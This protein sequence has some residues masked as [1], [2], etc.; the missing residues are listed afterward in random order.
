M[1][2]ICRIPVG[3]DLSKEGDGGVALI[4]DNECGGEDGVTVV[5]DEDCPRKYV[6]RKHD[7]NIMRLRVDRVDTRCCK[8]R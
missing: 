7:Q 6:K 2:T 3:K 4:L 8:A 5:W 1:F